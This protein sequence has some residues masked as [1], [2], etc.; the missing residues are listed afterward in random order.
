MWMMIKIIIFL[1]EKT[2]IIFFKIYFKTN[3]YQVFILARSSLLNIKVYQLNEFP[4]MKK[5]NWHYF[6]STKTVN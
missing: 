4:V 5:I 2:K 1:S 6:W 3:F